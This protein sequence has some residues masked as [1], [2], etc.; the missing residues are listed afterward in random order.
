MEGAE[1]VLAE[2]ANV[3]QAAQ[4]AIREANRFMMYLSF[5]G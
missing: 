3:R 1:T 5:V 4:H 2:A